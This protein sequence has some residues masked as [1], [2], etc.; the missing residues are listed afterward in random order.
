MVSCDLTLTFKVISGTNQVFF[1][2]DTI[3]LTPEMYKVDIFSKYHSFQIK[4]PELSTHL[5]TASP[6]KYV[7]I[8]NVLI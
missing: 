8:S 3:F 4:I 6:F 2:N 7:R 5:Y 1:S